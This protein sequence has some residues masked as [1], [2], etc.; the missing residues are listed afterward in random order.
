[1]ITVKKLVK[2]FGSQTVLDKLDAQ[3]DVGDVVSIIGPSGAGK[4]TFLR[5]LNLL[6]QPTSGEIWIN[7]ENILNAKRNISKL[8]QKMG[9]VFQS[10]NLFS[11]LTVLENLT[12]GPIRLK[13]IEPREAEKT[14]WE[15][16][17]LVGLKNHAQYYP[18][19]LSGGQQQRIAI[20]RCLAMKPE[21][22][23][24]DEPTSALDPTMV[25]EVLAVIRRL[26]REGMTLIIVT[27]EM[28]FAAEVSTKVFFMDQGMIYEQG[29]ANEIFKTPQKESTKRFLQKIRSLNIV[30]QSHNF[31]L[32]E[33]HGQIDAFC[34]KYAL[35]KKLN[36][37][38]CLTVEELTFDTLHHRFP[39]TEIPRMEIDVSYSEKDHSVT[40]RFRDTAR[41]GNPFDALN[42]PDPEQNHPGLRL[43]QGLATEILYEF[44][45]GENVLA[46]RF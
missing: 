22:M 33:L 15:L 11:H 41:P 35:S 21:I 25:S 24:F 1:M 5:C 12:L 10:F 34:Q 17:E 38:L 28:E 3:I 32:Y 31:N 8:R 30:V 42:E 36:Y 26:T 4:S 2:Y 44:V 7:G 14:A 13:K 40:L 9:M 19:Q 45:N 20:A 29:S 27:H 37:E 39:E 16:L 18:A 46:I 6:E 43:V 23:L